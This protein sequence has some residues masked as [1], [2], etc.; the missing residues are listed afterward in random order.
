MEGTVW[1]VFSS[2]TS[3]GQIREEKINTV[4]VFSEMAKQGK[5]EPEHVFGSSPN[6]EVG[7]QQ[8][9]IGRDCLNSLSRQFTLLWHQLQQYFRI[10]SQQSFTKTQ[11]PWN[12]SLRQVGTLR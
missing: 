1:M 7:M 6:K 9:C 3:N 12:S 5:R 8:V 4:A 11:L 10:L 2:D